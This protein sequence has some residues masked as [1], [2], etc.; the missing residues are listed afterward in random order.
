MEDQTGYIPEVV[1]EEG[2][3]DP[4]EAY[5]IVVVAAVG[6]DLEVVQ[7]VAVV[8]LPSLGLLEVVVDG[9]IAEAGH[10][11]ADSSQTLM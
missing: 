8:V 10:L 4:E 5:P 7:N 2:D 9:Q 6:I 3:A 11:G 1:P